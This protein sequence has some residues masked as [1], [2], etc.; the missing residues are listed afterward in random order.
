MHVD[1]LTKIVEYPG[2]RDLLRSHNITCFTEKHK[3]SGAAVPKL[4]PLTEDRRSVEHLI[5]NMGSIGTLSIA[6]F[7]ERSYAASRV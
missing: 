5:K 7:A 3:G 1:L 4:F 6:S 2:L